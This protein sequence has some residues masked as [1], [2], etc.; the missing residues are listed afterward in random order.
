VPTGSLEFMFSRKAVL[1]LIFSQIK[2]LRIL[3]WSS[4]NQDWRRL[5]TLMEGFY[6]YGDYTNFGSLSVAWKTWELR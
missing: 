6:V 4:S 5:K 3:S 1:N 2:I